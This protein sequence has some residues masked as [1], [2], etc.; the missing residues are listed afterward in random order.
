MVAQKDVDCLAN[1]GGT[2]MVNGA[3][4]A[5]QRVVVTE[6]ANGRFATWINGREWCGWVEDSAVQSGGTRGVFAF[7]VPILAAAGK[8]IVTEIKEWV[9]EKGKEAAKNAMC[10]A[11]RAVRQ[12]G[13]RVLVEA[14]NGAQA[15]VEKKALAAVSTIMPSTSDSVVSDL[16][17]GSEAPETPSGLTVEIRAFRPNGALVLP[18][19][20]LRLDEEYGLEVR[21][22]R[23]CYVRITAETPGQ[24][25]LCQYYPNQF[26]GY[27]ESRLV[28][29]NIWERALLPSDINYFAVREP[30][31]EK[32]VI[33]VE[34]STSRSY[35]YLP[36]GDRAEGC[37]AISMVKTRGG[38]FA[39]GEAKQPHA[40][41]VAVLEIPTTR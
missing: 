2:V 32:D 24:D 5:G 30:I 25:A 20:T 7:A 3:L 19:E 28:S 16:L 21:C 33:R 23:D 35:T 39:G 22:S 26:A 27:T 10:G 9:T 17:D 8:F 6:A 29:G 18:G 11:V 41:S 12:E 34:A 15:W 14:A 38:G 40:T 36:G 13:D 37:T 31:G 4:K 1:P